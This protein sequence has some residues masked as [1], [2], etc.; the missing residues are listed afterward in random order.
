M[1]LQHVLVVC[2]II[3]I[4]VCATCL[5]VLNEW[6]IVVNLKVGVWCKVWYNCNSHFALLSHQILEMD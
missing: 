3:A 4:K 5:H 6:P 2:L 1:K